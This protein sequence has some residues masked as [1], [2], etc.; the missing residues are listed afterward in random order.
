M[1]IAGIDTDSM[2]EEEK[3]ALHDLFGELTGEKCDP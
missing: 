3:D 2:S 1:C